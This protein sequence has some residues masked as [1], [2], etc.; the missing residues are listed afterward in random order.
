MLKNSNSKDMP[1]SVH[2]QET[3]Q[4]LMSPDSSPYTLH[5]TI[6]LLTI[7]TI[8]G[9]GS[10]VQRSMWYDKENHQVIS[11]L[12][13]LHLNDVALISGMKDLQVSTKDWVRT[14]W[15]KL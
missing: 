6:W 1:V 8:L 13:L 2:N 5:K 4:Q 7:V 11:A 3:T 12:R 9:S 15:S 14:Y 10:K